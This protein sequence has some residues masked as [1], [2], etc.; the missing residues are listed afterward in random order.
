MRTTVS[1]D[2]HLLD[3]AK[4]HAHERGVTLG[5]LVEDG[6]RRELGTPEVTSSP[7]IPTFDAKV[8]PRFDLSSNRAMW[9]FLDAGLPIDKLR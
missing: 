6:L 5:Q 7:P 8:Q 2:D 4:R 9:E 1:I 3:C